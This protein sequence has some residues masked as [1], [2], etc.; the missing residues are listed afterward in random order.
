MELIT[1]A[2]ILVR[3]LKEEEVEFIFGY[4][5]GAVLHIYDALFAQ[6]AV[7]HILVRHEQAA[8]HAAD[9]YSRACGKP[10]VVLV[11]SGPGVTNAVTGI[12]NAFMDSVP[13]VV[14]SGQVP[15][16]L[17][18]NDAFQEVDAVG[19]TR[20]CVK[21]NFLVKDINQLAETIKK[22]FFIA[23]TGRP[24][25]VL[26]DLPKDITIAKA[27]FSYPKKVKLRSY[28]PTVKG[29]SGQ[30]RKAVDLMLSAKRPMMYTG[31]GVIL[32]DGAAELTELTQLLGYP[33]TNTLMGLG[34]YPAT[35]PQFIGML[36]M[37]GTY[38]ANMG[39]HECDVLIAIGA[40]FDDRVT[41]K[42]DKFC[43]TAKIVHV[44]IDPSS[45]SKNVQVDIPIVGSVPNVLRAMINVIRE[46]KLKPAHPEAL[47]AWWRQI[48]E[49][50]DMKSL[51]YK[52]SDTVIKPQYVLQK[53]YQVT[54]GKA[55]ITSDVGQHQM[56]A[57]QYYHFDRPRQWIN[58][59][60]LGTMGFGL[61]AAM[62]A[63][64]AFP[65]QEVACVTGD[66]S[67]Q[68]MLQELSTMKQYHTPVKIVNL[69][70][71]YLGMVRQW[72]EFFYQKRYSMTY[73][74]ALPDFV[75]L[76]EAYGHVGMR[77]EKPGD[78]EGALREAFAMKDRTVFLDFLTDQGEN[79]FPMIP[80]GGGQNE[81]LL[82][83]RDEMVSV[84]DEGMVLL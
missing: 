69:N 24:G 46:E 74:D 75:M 39:M 51:H 32:S 16:A 45:I 82:A 29:H 52:N 33:I 64:L 9:G 35:H 7:T 11:T 17:I 56:W 77:I 3:C 60:G 21:H 84:H 50:R 37:H 48:D 19:I 36:G 79:V 63:K 71:Q 6:D 81:M 23:S 70:N 65:D 8:V 25:P 42:L 28:N 4:P 54:E 31:G 49:W 62:G 10:G 12:A 18:G 59:G 53:L 66:G 13:L 57:A 20:P 22:A 80:A 38:E 2:E 78:V 67:I 1:G 41:G 55:I 44:D 72:Q 15:T 40:R 73:M 68:M 30:I 58:S 27:E 76:A 5:G 14:F 43:P 47:A 34:A 61:P 83:E 26:I